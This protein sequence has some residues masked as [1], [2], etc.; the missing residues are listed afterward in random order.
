[1]NRVPDVNRI[2][3]KRQLEKLLQLRQ[4]IDLIPAIAGSSENNI[5][6]REALCAAVTMESIGHRGCSIGSAVVSGLTTLGLVILPSPIFVLARSILY[7]SRSRMGATTFSAPCSS[8]RVPTPRD[9]TVSTSCST[10]WTRR[11]ISS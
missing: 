11:M 4:A 10:L 1:M 6:V 7:P 5:V 9:M 3:G 2:E 8:Q